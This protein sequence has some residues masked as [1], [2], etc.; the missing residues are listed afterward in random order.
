MAPIQRMPSSLTPLEV[1]LTTLLQRIKPVAPIELPLTDALSCTSAEMPP[2][3]PLPPRD[4]AIEDGWAMR[5][6]DLAGASSYSPLPLPEPP[7]WV[8]AGDLMPDG[9]DCVA[10]ADSVDQSGP[11]PQVLIETIPGQGVR[12]A[13]EDHFGGTSAVAPGRIVTARDL[14]IARAAGLQR[15]KVRRPHVRIVNIP[16]KAGEAVTAPLIAENA[17]ASGAEIVLVEAR[18]RDAVAI[19]KALDGDYCDLL[20]TIGATGQGRTDAAIAAIAKCGQV[21]AH[22]IALKPGRASAVGCIGPVPVLALPGA[23][24]QALGGWWTLGL[25]ALDRL[26]GRSSRQTLT[27]PLSRKIASQVGIAEIV[28][29]QRAAESWIPLAVGDLSLASIAGADG[30]LVV[31]GGSEGFAADAPV[32]GYILRD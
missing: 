7:V 28:L 8:E 16:A 13:G 1:A 3:R 23:P 5:S 15:L 20:V 12:R 19:A 25:P 22:G 18:D 21:V 14:L 29:L 27:L 26:S 24:D 32:D 4:I 30:F 31:S 2:L 10:E 6:R 17:R 9:C 11:I